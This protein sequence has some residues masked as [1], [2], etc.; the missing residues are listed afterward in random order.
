MSSTQASDST[1]AGYW[2]LPATPQHRVG[3]KLY[4]QPD[5]TTVLEV[6]EKLDASPGSQ[7]QSRSE[8]VIQ[9]M[10]TDGSL[11]SLFNSVLKSSHHALP[12]DDKSGSFPDRS[13]YS[14]YV[15]HVSYYTKGSDSIELDSDI[16]SIRVSFSVLREW[17]SVEGVLESVWQDDRESKLTIPSDRKY[18][19]EI[20]GATVALHDQFKASGSR[21]K[22][23]IEYDPYFEILD[24]P[25]SI[26]GVVSDWIRPLQRLMMFLSSYYAPITTI[27]LRRHESEK[28]IRSFIRRP[29]QRSS[30]PPR[31]SCGSISIGHR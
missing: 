25:I 22:S 1:V 31:P 10:G 7:V 29:Q 11:Y 23:S 17:M 28:F 14:Q 19:C 24:P 13:E 3:G 9:G 4:V 6:A 27:R 21:Y 16:A 18:E 26:S 30:I 15:W 5:G 2:Y 20:N 12:P 8:Q